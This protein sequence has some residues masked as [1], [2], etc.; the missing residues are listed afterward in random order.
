M[1]FIYYYYYDILQLSSTKEGLP[2]LASGLVSRS[3]WDGSGRVG[4]GVR[5]KGGVANR[6]LQVRDA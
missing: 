6:S 1:L 4:G 2:L 5:G 3:G